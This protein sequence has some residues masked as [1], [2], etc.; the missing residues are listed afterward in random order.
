MTEIEKIAKWLKKNE[1]GMFSLLGEMIRIQSGSH[2]KAGV[3]KVSSLI[4]SRMGRGAFT[5]TR[6][7]EETLG[8]HLVVRS[9]E[10]GR[11]AGGILLTGHM[12][13][14]FPEDT[15]FNWY[16]EEETICRG[17]GIVDMKGG[18]VAG[19]FALEAL[20]ACGL[21]EGMPVTFLFNS[22]E[23]IGSGGSRELIVEEA[24]RS[25]FAFVLECGGLSGEVVTGRK[26]NI[27]IRVE[28]FGVAGH[29][30]F[31]GKDKGSAI[32]EMAKKTIAFEALN[33]PER[34]V[35]ANVGTIE[36]GIGPNTVPAAAVA[37][38]DFRFVTKADYEMLKREIARIAE[39]TTVPNT[40]SRFEITSERPP[41]PETE[42][43]RK[44]FDIVD[45]VSG[46]LNIPVISE[47]RQGV[48]DANLI[49]DAGT[50]VLDGLGPIGARDH[51]EEE[52]MVKESLLA[53]TTL[54]ACAIAVCWQ[55]HRDGKLF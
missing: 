2:N 55:R 20:S 14:V 54:L 48:S 26:G 29:A 51:S 47:F 9:P 5:C 16:R 28:A 8:D 40:H 11:S 38:V 32:L 37:R 42:G 17:P 36:G 45:A 13:T 1:K 10:A 12:D 6:H 4:E 19:I 52:Y 46:H 53:R 27:S 31:A 7:H 18:L 44:L 22:D 49:A 3:D 25:D 30:A 41:M 24:K 23:E 35:S 34:G 21:L 15:T 33:A 50:P 39:T 43:N